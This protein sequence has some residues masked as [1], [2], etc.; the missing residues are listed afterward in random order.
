MSEKAIE[1]KP[2]KGYVFIKDLEEGTSFITEGGLEG[3][4][5]SNNEGSALCY[6]TKHASNDEDVRKYWLKNTKRIA[7]QTNVKQKGS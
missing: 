4:L 3:T 5:I 6:F 7:P 2:I 1:I